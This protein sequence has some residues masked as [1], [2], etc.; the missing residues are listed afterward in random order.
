MD[1]IG[2]EDLG[3]RCY[4]CNKSIAS[5]NINPCDLSIVTNI[6]KNKEKYQVALNLASS[7]ELYRLSAGP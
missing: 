1:N 3:F 4:F 2:L 7:T 6:D 5:D